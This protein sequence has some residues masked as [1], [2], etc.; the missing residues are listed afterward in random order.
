M[1]FS[2]LCWVCST[3][4]ANHCGFW[5]RPFGRYVYKFTFISISCF[6]FWNDNA[7]WL[8]LEIKSVPLCK[9]SISTA[10]W[11]SQLCSGCMWMQTMK[12]YFRSL[13][14][15][16]ED[17]DLHRV[18]MINSQVC[19]KAHLE[20]CNPLPRI[21]YGMCIWRKRISTHPGSNWISKHI[22]TL[23]C[24][25]LVSHVVRLIAFNSIRLSFCVHSWN[26][27]G[28]WE[29]KPSRFDLERKSDGRILGSGVFLSFSFNSHTKLLLSSERLWQWR[30]NSIACAACALICLHSSLSLTIYPDT[31]NDITTVDMGQVNHTC[32][33]SQIYT[34]REAT[35]IT[36]V[37]EQKSMAAMKV[38]FHTQIP[39][40]E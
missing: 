33:L 3:F 5:P 29:P 9:P 39:S 24:D 31:M 35:Q 25:D 14:Q 27:F 4:L 18:Q 2:A 34:I 10:A 37:G 28:P 21:E 12:S 23:R 13:E 40:P 32:F 38:L 22:S 8:F 6:S 1:S 7:A 30:C 11:C 15:I 20:E 19:F 16:V 17:W 36:K 26:G